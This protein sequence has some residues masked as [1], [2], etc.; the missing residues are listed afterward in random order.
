MDDIGKLT[1]EGTVGS[2]ENPEALI[3]MERR[4]AIRKLG[5]YAAY[6]A[7]AMIA[8]TSTNSSAGCGSTC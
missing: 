6:V 7:P 8:L 3:S 1:E 2:G 5:K 4:D